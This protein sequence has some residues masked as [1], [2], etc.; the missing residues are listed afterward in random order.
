MLTLLA[1]LFGIN[2]PAEP[3]P[4]EE[5]KEEVVAEVKPKKKPAVKKAASGEKKPRAKKTK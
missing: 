2:K 4:V 5:V 1:K 3:T